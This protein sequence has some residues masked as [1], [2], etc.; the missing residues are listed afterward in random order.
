MGLK[1]KFISFCEQSKVANELKMVRGPNDPSTLE[2]YEK[3]N[4]LKREILEAIDE[5]SN[6]KWYTLWYS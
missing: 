2:A 6:F 4:K 1:S 3:A 5:N